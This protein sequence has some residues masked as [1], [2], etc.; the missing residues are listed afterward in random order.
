MAVGVGGRSGPLEPQVPQATP[1]WQLLAGLVW[2]SASPQ[3][4]LWALARSW[5][6]VCPTV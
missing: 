3:M 5:Q 4:L 6:P 2:A 1:K